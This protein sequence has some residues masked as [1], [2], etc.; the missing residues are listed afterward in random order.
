MEKLP[1]GNKFE[2]EEER[3]ELEMESFYKR[4]FNSVEPKRISLE[5][6]AELKENGIP[7]FY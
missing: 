1:I 2:S 7:I 6:L 5:E 4:S 3:R